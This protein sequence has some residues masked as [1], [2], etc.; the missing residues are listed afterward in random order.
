VYKC[1]K[2]PY[3]R[4]GVESREIGAENDAFLAHLS[5]L[6]AAARNFIRGRGKFRNF[7]AH[8]A[9]NV[10]ITNGPAITGG[11]ALI[12]PH[13]SAENYCHEMRRRRPLCLSLGGRLV[14]VYLS[15][16]ALSAKRINELMRNVR[17]RLFIPARRLRNTRRA[18]A[19][20][21]RFNPLAT[22]ALLA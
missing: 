14:C 1:N 10:I 21:F 20:L 13:T 6:L 15:L 4:P 12:F 7:G 17:G 9:E 8:A 2:F 3:K 16:N 11:R 5:F 22:F 18:V 19:F